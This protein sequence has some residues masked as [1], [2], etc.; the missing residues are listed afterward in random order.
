MLTPS[1]MRA[2]P[3]KR[4]LKRRIL[5]CSRRRPRR[6]ARP[7]RAAIARTVRR[8]PKKS[9][10]PTLMAA[11]SAARERFPSAFLLREL[12]RESRDVDDRALVSP[13]ADL[14]LLVPGFHP[15]LNPA[16]GRGEHLRG[17]RHRHADRGSG[18]MRNVDV[19]PDRVVP[20]IQ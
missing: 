14:L 20:R 4:L 9:S 17:E 6:S 19:R 18:E 13:L 10:N 15:K 12:G 7:A 3:S 16:V 11:P 2:P 5:T 8:P 1:G